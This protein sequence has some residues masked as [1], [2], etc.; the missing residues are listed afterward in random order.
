MHR[1]GDKIGTGGTDVF[2]TSMQVALANIYDEASC[3]RE[4]GI[5]V[6][7]QL[8][9]GTQV[10]WLTLNCAPSQQL[11]RSESSLNESCSAHFN[12][13]ACAFTN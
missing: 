11:S 6:D 13:R 10:F 8:L 1:S 9:E 3:G 2:A 7:E 4:V 12:Q 5:C